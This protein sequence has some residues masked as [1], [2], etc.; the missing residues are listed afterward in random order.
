MSDAVNH[1]KHYSH[2]SGI[3]AIDI[4]EQ[5]GFT[6]GNAVKYLWRVGRK[7]DAVEDLKKA[8]W[9]LERLVNES[10]TPEPDWPS[11]QLGCL[12][13][14]VIATDP[15]SVCGRALKVLEEHLTNGTEETTGA[16][17]LACEGMIEVVD[18][19]IEEIA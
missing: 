13:G 1:P 4:V 11:F 6:L 9:Y 16:W 8:R 10:T 18:D 19:A 17:L 2:P 15:Y 12:I 7:G 3:E 5:L 14:R